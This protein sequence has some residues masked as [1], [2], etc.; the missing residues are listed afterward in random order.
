M[1]IESKLYRFYI[2]LL[3]YYYMIT[4]LYLVKLGTIKKLTTY[5]KT[6]VSILLVCII[7]CRTTMF[8]CFSSFSNEAETRLVT[9]WH[10]SHSAFLTNVSKVRQSKECS[11]NTRFVSHTSL[12][13]Y[14][15]DNHRFAINLGPGGLKRPIYTNVIFSGSAEWH[16][17]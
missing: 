11:L 12:H 10:S 4:I 9:W 8:A 5:S 17:H 16:F 6:S 2:S 15:I 14:M 1:Y 3:Q 13:A 7:S